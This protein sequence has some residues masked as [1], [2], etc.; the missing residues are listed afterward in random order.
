MNIREYKKSLMIVKD[1]DSEIISEAYFILKNSSEYEYESKISA[2][3]ERIIRECG[4]YAK[5]KHRA[6]ST[7]LK[8]FFAAVLVICVAILAVMVA[9]RIF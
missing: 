7:A 3:A 6:K 1:I 9:V 8:G 2:E 5:K 4:A